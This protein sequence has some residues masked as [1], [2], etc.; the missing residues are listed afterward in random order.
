[1]Q[2]KDSV[3]AVLEVTA[4]IDDDAPMPL[5]MWNEFDLL[6]EHLLLHRD[7]DA[8]LL[9]TVE[10]NG[11]VFLYHN[12]NDYQVYLTSN[13][14]CKFRGDFRV[15]STGKTDSEVVTQ[16]IKFTDATKAELREVLEE[17]EEKL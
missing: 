12:K 13:E 15:C 8:A 11:F 4:K 9:Y 6:D 7:D 17:I 16:Y 2:Y 10:R 14:D 1:M 3:D 5:K